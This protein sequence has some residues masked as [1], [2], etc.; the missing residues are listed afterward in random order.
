MT[1]ITVTTIITVMSA[2]TMPAAKPIAFLDGAGPNVG[3]DKWEIMIG[4]VG[5]ELTDSVKTKILVHY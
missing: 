2:T 5:S 3:R 4:T 1:K